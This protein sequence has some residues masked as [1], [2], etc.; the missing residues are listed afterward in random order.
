LNCSVKIQQRPSLT[1]QL[2]L[3]QLQIN[4]F[5]YH[6]MFNQPQFPN[7]IQEYLI[8]TVV[9]YQAKHDPLLAIEHHSLVG[10]ISMSLLVC[11]S[12]VARRDM[13][14]SFSWSQELLDTY[15]RKPRGIRNPF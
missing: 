2:H 15:M 4:L 3:I 5:R 7:L 9:L 6:S 1:L 10:H 13:N 11:I 12:D 8:Q 14:D